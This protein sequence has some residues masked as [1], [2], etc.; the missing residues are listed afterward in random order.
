MRKI[1]III[2]LLALS[3]S[4]TFGQTDSDSI[5]MKKV[6]GSYQFYQGEQR[7]KMSQLI[8]TMKPNEQ[9]YEQIQ[10]A[11]SNYI[12][13]IALS[14]TGGFLIGWYIGGALREGGSNWNMI[15]IGASLVVVSIPVSNNFN[16]KARQAVETYNSG[17]LQT[18]SFWDKSEL[19]ISFSG[20]GIGLT[21][22]F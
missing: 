5:T 21:L 20:S 15:G 18:S 2:A 10:S 7:L 16:I 3:M 4:F 19:K 11:H 6:L 13:A 9:A 14:S 1:A 8:N 12:I 17:L 22:N